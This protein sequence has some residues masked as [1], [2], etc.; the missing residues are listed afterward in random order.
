MKVGA[1]LI[2]VV[3]AVVLGVLAIYFDS[4]RLAG[5]SSVAL[6]AATVV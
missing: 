6:A 3:L 5:G 1:Q 2:L 4:G